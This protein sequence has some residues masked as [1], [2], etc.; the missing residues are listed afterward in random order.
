MLHRVYLVPGMFGFGTLASYK[1]FGHIERAIKNEFTARKKEVV[2]FI[3]DVPPTASIRRRAEK[4]ARLIAKTHSDGPEDKGP[5]HLIGHSTGGL[6]A[7]L[8]A[9]SCKTLLG[10]QADLRWLDR[11]RSVTCVNTPHYGTPLATF[12]AT[13]KGQRMLSAVSALTVVG[14]S[15]GAPPLAVASG[16]V[17]GLGR[18]DKMFG[19]E[20]SLMDRTVDT[21]VA[22]LEEAK[23][24]DVRSFLEAVRGDQGAVLQ[25]TPEAMDLFTAGVEDREG[26]R[27]QSTV[28]MVP[29]QTTPMLPKLFQSPWRVVSAP[30]FSTMSRLASSMDEHYACAPA[31]LSL[32]SEE[33]LR[34]AFG[35]LPSQ[36]S[37]DGVVP[38]YSQVW[39][40]LVWAGVADHLDVIGHFSDPNGDHRDWLS[41]GA[42]FT[43]EKFRALTGAIVDGIADL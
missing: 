32:A 29:P 30:L 31:A 4:L 17:L 34:R 12:F 22:T 37:S 38:L 15:L 11:V 27:Y 35:V 28:S 18:I 14:L 8:V 13:A 1:Y 43:T 39:G 40:D 23:R 9:S 33:I 2:C 36:R 20:L 7:R 10:A 41:S 26:I 21:L 3:A 42:K 24:A 5:I 16:M 19:L 6:D 25:L